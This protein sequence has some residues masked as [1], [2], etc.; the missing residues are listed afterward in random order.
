[1]NCMAW[2][3]PS[4]PHEPF[5]PNPWPP[6]NPLDNEIKGERGSLLKLISFLR[7]RERHM[8]KRSIVYRAKTKLELSSA[9]MDLDGNDVPH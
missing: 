1:M 7:P 5:S 4:L 3:N 2:G 6:E 9:D 8:V